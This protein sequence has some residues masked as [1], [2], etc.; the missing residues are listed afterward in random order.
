MN[1][2]KNFL[3]EN[4]ATLKDINL[5]ILN[6]MIKILH[7][8]KNNDGRLFLIG[9]GGSAGHCSHAV[10]DFRKICNIQAF[11][12]TDNVS[13]L[14]ARIN[15]EGWENSY[16]N[17][18]KGSRL[19]SK[20]VVM[21]YSVGGGSKEK[22]ISVNLVNSIDYSN[23]VGAKVISIIGKETGYANKNSDAC[24]VFK[25][26]DRN[27]ITPITEGLTSVIWHLFVSHP[28]LKENQTTWESIK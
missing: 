22:N 2:S 20:D 15:D 24:L 21:V 9:V 23:E 17:F 3:H 5:E 4:I 11:T 10:N 18:L 13:E 7:E 28:D 1:F 16:K 27:F 8:C 6:K 25:I 26:Q 14:T 12:P 19:M